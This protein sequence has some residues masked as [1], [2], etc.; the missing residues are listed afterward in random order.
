[1]RAYD[2]LIIQTRE[3][4]T[5]LRHGQILAMVLSGTQVI[6]LSLSILGTLYI[7]YSLLRTPV[8]AIWDWSKPTATRR[9]VGAL[10]AVAMVSLVVFFWGPDWAVL[11]QADELLLRTRESTAKLQSLTADLEGSIGS[12]RFRGAL[13]LKRPN[14]ARIDLRGIELG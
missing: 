14:L 5:A 7:I 9:L 6:M 4:P 1:A 12:Q 2:A 10:G 11:S 13:V 3:F 8:K